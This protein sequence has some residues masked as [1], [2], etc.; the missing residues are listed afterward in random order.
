MM[1]SAI[2]MVA[3]PPEIW[4]KELSDLARDALVSERRIQ[5]DSNIDVE[6]ARYGL[7][8][9]QIENWVMRL[10]PKI[11]DEYIHELN[12]HYLDILASLS[13][14]AEEDEELRDKF[15]TGRLGK[16]FT[17]PQKMDSHIRYFEELV[18]DAGLED[19]PAVISRL[20]FLRR[21]Q[22]FTGEQ[23]GGF[24]IVEIQSPFHL[25]GQSH[26]PVHLPRLKQQKESIQPSSIKYIERIEST[27]L[28]DSLREEI[29]RALEPGQGVNFSNPPHV[30]ITEILHEY[31]YGQSEEGERFIR[32]FYNDGSEGEPFPLF[33]LSGRSS[34]EAETIVDANPI[35]ASLISMRHLDM[36]AKVDMAWFSNQQASRSRPFAETDAFCYQRTMGQLQ[37]LKNPI[38][39]RLYQTGLQPAVVGFYRALVDWLRQR[40]R[41]VL[42]PK[43]V[44]VPMY[45]RG[46]GG[47]SEGESWY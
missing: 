37:Q 24:S 47:Y 33:A 12:A 1:D 8:C 2:R 18:Q 32:V 19:D 11:A 35:R 43:L 22:G 34:E 21:V 4:N 3:I 27:N 14:M 23:K 45:H 29:Q 7:F 46:P 36:D 30:V 5:K 28:F 25:P 42:P 38:Q 13:I 20:S 40:E 6:R 15:V 16:S 17:P 31:V 9:N 44:V 41:K 26:P 39:L 10:L